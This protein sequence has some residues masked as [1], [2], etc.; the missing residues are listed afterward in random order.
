MIDSKEIVIS[1]AL[2]V[3][4]ALCVSF[5]LGLASR[6]EAIEISVPAWMDK[7]IHLVIKKECGEETIK[8]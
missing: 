8:E 1:C 3:V 6:K 4:I 2:A 5:F 7:D